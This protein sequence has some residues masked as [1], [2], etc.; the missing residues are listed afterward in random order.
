MKAKNEIVK[1]RKGREGRKNK[2]EKL[3][4]VCQEDRHLW[5]LCSVGRRGGRGLPGPSGVPL[6]AYLPPR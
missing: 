3:R 4:Y 5:P 1:G 6:I 2:T